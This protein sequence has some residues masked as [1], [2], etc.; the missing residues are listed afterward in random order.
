MQRKPTAKAAPEMSDG[1]S[2]SVV[3]VANRLSMADPMVVTGSVLG[4]DL[5]R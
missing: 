2:D 4:W 3:S 1:C 5:T